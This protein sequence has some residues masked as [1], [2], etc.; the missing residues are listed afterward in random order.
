MAG[1]RPF[2]SGSF[3]GG[4][5]DLEALKHQVKPNRGRLVVLR[6]PAVM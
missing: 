4:S 3:L 2:N 5:V 1:Q 6:P